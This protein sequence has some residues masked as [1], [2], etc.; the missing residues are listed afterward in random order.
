MVSDNAS[1]ISRALRDLAGFQWFGCSA[2]HLNLIAQAAF[3]KVPVTARLVKR[4]KKIVEYVRKSTTASNKLGEYNELLNET[5]SKLHQEN[6]TRWWSILLMFK[7]I[8]RNINALK[9]TLFELG[10][11]LLVPHPW[12]QKAMQEIVDIFEPFKTIADDL[13]S[14]KMITGSLIL[15]LFYRLKNGILEPK[16]SDLPMIRYMR[17]VMLVKYQSRYTWAQ[18]RVFS[19]MTTLDVRFKSHP[20]LKY[21]PVID[22]MG[23]KLVKYEMQKVLE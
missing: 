21:E 20:C 7:S 18:K 22:H 6:T 8:L 11:S 17:K 2:H 4:T 16:D 1:D 9:C 23:E 10:K 12:E 14:E 5:P 13:G 3:N 15:P 19:A